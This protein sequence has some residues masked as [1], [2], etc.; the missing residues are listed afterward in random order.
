[1]TLTIM[2]GSL[3]GVLVTLTSVGAGAIGATMLSYLYPKRLSPSRLIA[4]DIVHA[5]PLALFAGIGHLWIGDVN[6]ALL[7]TLLIDSI[8]GVIVGYMLSTHLPATALRRILAVILLL[9]SI[10]MLIASLA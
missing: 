3:L 6:F 8:P 1:M 10:K 4:T 9:V 5:V 2:A 7:G